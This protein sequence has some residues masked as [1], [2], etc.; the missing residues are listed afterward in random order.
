[1]TVV[2]QLYDLLGVDEDIDRHNQSI[3]SLDTAALEDTRQL[4]ETRQ[5]AEETRASLGKQQAERRDL[6]LDS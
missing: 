1:M 2:Q 6:E 3:S 4:E 5:A